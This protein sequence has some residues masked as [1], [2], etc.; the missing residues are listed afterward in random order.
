MMRQANF[1]QT[2][3]A[4]LKGRVLFPVMGEPSPDLIVSG[5][6]FDTTDFASLLASEASI[7][8]AVNMLPYSGQ[9]KSGL[10]IAIEMTNPA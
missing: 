2:C 6:S 8:G 1:L 4:S 5:S 7:A 3:A 10:R 9:W